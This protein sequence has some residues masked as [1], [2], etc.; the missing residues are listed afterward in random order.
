[1][2]VSL[3]LPRKGTNRVKLVSL[4]YQATPLTCR[5]ETFPRSSAKSEKEGFTHEHGK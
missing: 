4:N 3:T 1:M 2:G 5:R